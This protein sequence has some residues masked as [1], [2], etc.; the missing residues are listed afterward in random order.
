MA[1]KMRNESHVQ[2]A[3][4]QAL[5][6]ACVALLSLSL[7]PIMA[8]QLACAQDDC[9]AVTQQLLTCQVQLAQYSICNSGRP[10]AKLLPLQRKVTD[11][12]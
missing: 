4:K 1:C 6:H 10:L 3:V 9:S 12:C 7:F 11:L 2:A 5:Y 8:S